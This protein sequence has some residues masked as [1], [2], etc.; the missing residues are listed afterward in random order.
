MGFGAERSALG[1]VDTDH[2]SLSEPTFA[3]DRTFS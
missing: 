2:F 1:T 3:G